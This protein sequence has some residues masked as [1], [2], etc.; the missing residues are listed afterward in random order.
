MSR[1]KV[2]PKKAFQTSLAATARTEPYDGLVGGIAEILEVARRTSARAVNA[3]MT[4]TYWEIGRRTVEYEQKGA[5][6]A[7]YGKR[8]LG[9]LAHDLAA[10]FGRGFSYPNLNRFRQFY[11]AFPRHEILST[12]SRESSPP[13]LQTV[14]AE[15]SLAQ[16][17][18]RFS[19]PWSAYVRLLSVRNENARAFYETEALRAGWSVRQLDRQIQSQFYERTALSRNKAA[20]L[21]KGA[22]PQPQ[23][24]LTAEDEIKDP[25][26]L[27]VQSVSKAELEEL[28]RRSIRLGANDHVDGLML[29]HDSGEETHVR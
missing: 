1:R 24:A 9:R 6:R 27:R 23:D 20:M 4:A 22:I 29:G 5:M 13:I 14:S 17:A 12:P 25:C 10:R 15:S 11:L 28:R 8:L 26:V 3:I 7:E 19:L 18:A 2:A 21:R 16:V